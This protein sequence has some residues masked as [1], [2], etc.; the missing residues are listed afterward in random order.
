MLS[1]Y[2]VLDLTDERGQLA[3]LL[4]AQLGADV[5]S[6][7]PS[8]GASTRAL[9]PFVDDIPGPD[10]SLMHLAYNRGKRSVRADHVDL[11]AL[12][13]TS[14]VV[15]HSGADDVDLA[16]LRAA[17]PHLI[18]VSVSAFGDT[19][20]KSNW[21]AS[22]L[23]IAAASGQMSLT[24][25]SDRAPLRISAPQAFHHAALEATIG[26]VVALMA[27]PHVG[28]Q[29]LDVSAQQSFMQSTQVAMLNAGVGA[30]DMERHAGGSRIGPYNLRLVYPAKDG[31]VAV[32]FLFGEMIGRFTQKLMQWVWEEGY[33]SE[34]IRDLDYPAFFQ[35]FRTGALAPTT[36]TEATDAVA[37]LTS[38][39]T[40]DEL[41]AIARA[42][43]LLIAQVAT[44]ED[45]LGNAHFAERGYWEQVEVGEGP[46]ARSVKV[47]GPWAHTTGVALRPLGGAPTIGQHDDEI[48]EML[49][50]TVTVPTPAELSGQ[51][52]LAAKS[53]G[54][55]TP[56][57]S[58]AYIPLEQAPRRALEGLKVLDFTWVIAGPMG[59]RVLADHGATIVRIETERRI[60]VI[61]AAQPFLPGKGGIEDT[62]LWHSIAAGKHSVQLDLSTEGGRAVARDLARWADVVVESFAPGFMA[63]IGLDYET[64]RSDNP[65]LVMVSSAL[66][67]QVGP[68]SDFAGFGN[69][70][71]SIAGF[72]DMTG[73]PDRSPAGPYTAYT[74]YVSPRFLALSVLAAA[75]HARRTGEGQFI[76]LSQ[77]EAA[78]HLLTP[79]LL[80]HA[81]NGRGFSRQGN[82]DQHLAPHGAYQVQGTDQW[83]AIAC[84]DDDQWRRLAGLLD[85]ADLASL[86]NGER[87]ARQHEIDGIIA[88]WTVDQDSLALQSLLQDHHVCAHQVQRSGQCHADPQLIHREHFRMVPHSVHGEVMVEGPH[89][90]YSVTPPGPVWGGQVLGEHTMWALEEI[91][92]YDEERITE[93][94]VGDVLR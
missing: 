27:R 89:V 49:Q 42:K 74:D 22:D 12:A 17:N 9:P 52:P 30:P 33:C 46:A 62:G 53:G 59:T 51:A 32:T 45:L 54:H 94:V 14:D 25:D 6:V 79:A 8:D 40:K 84:T 4:L 13:A 15:L 83:V 86:T 38:T 26:A 1:P 16:A 77:S 21:L 10:R 56:N 3:G 60:D 7:E 70:A 2:R 11:R 47:P 76:D 28:G 93:L 20:P 75:D 31:Y 37:A 58:S 29:H 44:T 55:D 65:S 50:R 87:L 92:G 82:A 85:R 64:L 24:G 34:Y 43:R 61:R 71:A 88:A 80:E 81:V 63:S 72:T 67:G 66:M 5:I 91:L 18:T 68:L 41:F 39:L 69:L 78:I 73:W 19:G 90:R 35:L 48:P 23:T 36:L 57:D